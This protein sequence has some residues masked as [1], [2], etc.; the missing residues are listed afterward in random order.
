MCGEDLNVWG[1]SLSEKMKERIKA[2]KSII[3]RVQGSRDVDDLEQ[4]YATEKELQRLLKV[5]EEFWHQ[6]SKIF[7]LKFGDLNTWAFHNI[8]N[9]QRK[10]TQ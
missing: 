1:K 2:Q 10:R 8:T 3:N 5:E 7:W 9:G 4:L 6:R